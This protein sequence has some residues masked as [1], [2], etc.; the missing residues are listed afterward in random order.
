[1]SFYSLSTII[2]GQ[3][4]F[5][6]GILAAVVARSRVLAVTWATVKEVGKRPTPAET[7]SRPA[8]PHLT[9]GLSAAW[10][11]ASF[12][13]KFNSIVLYP[14]LQIILDVVLSPNELKSPNY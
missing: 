9:T 7:L 13:N 6:K 10:Y 3:L 8:Q 4:S 11:R 14:G 12:I 5:D 1:M 2:A